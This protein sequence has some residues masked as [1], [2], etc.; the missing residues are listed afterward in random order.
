MAV[1]EKKTNTN[2]YSKE[3]ENFKVD[4]IKE[5]KKSDKSASKKQDV[6]VKS[7][8]RNKK[9]AK[10]ETVK[11]PGLFKLIGRWFRGV[12]KELKNAHWPTKNEMLKYSIATIVFVLFFALF[13]LGIEVIMSLLLDYFG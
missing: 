1:K 4:E 11:K 12:I 5:N 13:F 2:K 7:A 6:K 3:V 10:K 9:L 8:D